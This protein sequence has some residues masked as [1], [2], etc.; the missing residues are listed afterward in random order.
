MT[1]PYRI[2]V[3]RLTDL[4]LPLPPLLDLF[5]KFL[6]HRLILLQQPDEPA[7]GRLDLLFLGLVLGELVQRLDLVLVG[8]GELAGGA[9]QLVRLPGGGR[10]GG[11]IQSGL[12]RETNTHRCRS[13]QG[14]SDAAM[15]P[16][17][18]GGGL[19]RLAT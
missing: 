7:L 2:V 13:T 6:L 11:R 12:P 1:T 14:P 9:D 3:T 5:P 17:A 19:T 15:T 4:E 16:G 18:G 10:V 8:S